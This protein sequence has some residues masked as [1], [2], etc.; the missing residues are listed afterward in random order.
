MLKLRN[1]SIFFT[2][3]LINFLCLAQDTVSVMSYNLL[4]YGATWA[5]SDRYKDL[6]TIIQHAKPDIMMVCE[7]ED[8]QAPQYLLDSAFNKAGV[9]TYTRAAFIDGPDTDNML[10][11][12][13]SKIGL[14]SQK[15]IYTVLRDISQYKLYKVVA[16]GD[17]AFMYFH[18]AHLKAGSLS[19]D[20]TQRN[21]EISAFC[22]NI[23]SLSQNSNILIAGDFNFKTSTEPAFSTLTGAGCSH[24]FYDPINQIGLWN[25]NSA[26]SQIHTQ[27]T[28][29]SA[30]AGCC[31]GATG[32]LDDRFDFIMVNNS[33]LSGTN[34][35]RYVIGS[36]KAFGNDNL[37]MN[38]A[39]TDA[40][41]NTAVPANVAQAL[42]NM[43]DHLPVYMKIELKP[44]FVGIKEQEKNTTEFTIENK[45]VNGNPSL[46]VSVLKEGQFKLTVRDLTGKT[47]FQNTYYFKSGQHVID[48]ELMHLSEGLY[49]ADLKKDSEF[50][51]CLFSH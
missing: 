35:A 36:Y 5:N 14:R 15:Q 40:P 20:E 46:V 6:R 38:K 39:I 42:F 12:N 50:S 45:M 49:L 41:A 34:K 21:S 1:I 26:Y 48:T 31:G 2:L 43:S 25:N 3:L 13:T 7:L 32:G 8:A 37:H 16:P 47:L 33:L 24:T 18:M 9:G 22:S 30:N 10:F 23:A 28:R 44:S 11:Y 19:S 51:R 4:N 27:S 17:T 29:S